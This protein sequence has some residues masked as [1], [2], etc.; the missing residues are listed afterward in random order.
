MKVFRANLLTLESGETVDIIQSGDCCNV[1]IVLN[2]KDGGESLLFTL[3][4]DGG[5]VIVASLY[6]EGEAEPVCCVYWKD[7]IPNLSERNNQV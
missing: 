4:L 1:D 6:A 5:K 2:K 3:D 7:V